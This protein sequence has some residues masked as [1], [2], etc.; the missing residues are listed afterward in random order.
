MGLTRSKKVPKKVSR[1]A[2]QN[3]YMADEIDHRQSKKMAR[4]AT[5]TFWKPVQHSLD[6]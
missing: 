3:L 4:G 6:Y 2:R 1:V 5:G